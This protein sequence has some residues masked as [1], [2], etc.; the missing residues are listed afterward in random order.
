MVQK[1]QPPLA[2]LPSCPDAIRDYLADL[3]GMPLP[4]PRALYPR[5]CSALVDVP[6]A[7]VRADGMLAMT[8]GN[9]LLMDPVISDS[10]MSTSVIMCNLLHG[11]SSSIAL[12]SDAPNIFQVRLNRSEGGTSSAS[13]AQ[14]CRPDLIIVAS[15]CTLLVGEDKVANHLSDAVIDLKRK[16]QSG[17]SAAHYGSVPYILGYAASGTEVIFVAIDASGQVR[18][19][20]SQFLDSG[21]NCDIGHWALQGVACHTLTLSLKG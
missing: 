15:C 11:V 20:K 5:I 9:L 10:E 14:K 7:I 19:V 4:V 16:L 3:S 21:M 13:M 1:L 18:V 12:A 2:A 17:F 8:M 6:N